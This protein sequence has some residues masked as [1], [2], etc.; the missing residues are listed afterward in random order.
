MSMTIE[1][2]LA[3]AGLT[4]TPAELPKLAA[5]IEDMDRLALSLRGPRPYADEPLSAFRPARA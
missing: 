5:A 2:R 1:E 4:P 3:T